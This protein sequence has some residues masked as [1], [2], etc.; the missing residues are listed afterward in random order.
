MFEGSANRWRGPGNN[1]FR[2]NINRA[3]STGATV[4]LVIVRTDDVAHVEGG[5]DASKVRK[6]FFL[7]DEVV[8]KVTEWDGDRYA[9]AFAKP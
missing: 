2:E 1:E 4:R 7:K 9:I 8:G 6:E 3:F 5:G